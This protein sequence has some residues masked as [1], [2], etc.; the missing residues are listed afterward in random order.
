MKE[1]I[2]FP[3]GIDPALFWANLFLYAYEV[4]YK[5]DLISL[6]KVK[7]RHFHLTKR[8]IDDLCAFNNGGEFGK[9]HPSVM[10]LFLREHSIIP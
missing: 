9:V 7:A 10:Y 5:T 3:T 4:N 8:F 1:A 6:D 2:G